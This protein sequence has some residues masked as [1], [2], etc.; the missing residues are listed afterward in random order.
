MTTQRVGSFSALIRQIQEQE[1]RD[2]R[3][4]QP[5]AARP[6]FTPA[7]RALSRLEQAA[8]RIARRAAQGQQPQIR[9]TQAQLR[10]TQAQIQRN[11]QK[12][13]DAAAERARIQAGLSALTQSGVL[14]GTPAPQT[15][16]ATS[17]PPPDRTQL[18]PEERQNLI[19]T[20]G[21][22]FLGE[23]LELKEA[24]LLEER[25]Q[26]VREGILG[27][28]APP[29][30]PISRTEQFLRGVGVSGQDFSRRAGF[31]KGI[32]EQLS[33]LI[34]KT[35]EDIEKDRK[36]GLLDIKRLPP[37]G[38]PTS[39]A[40]AAG[41]GVGGI[42]VPEP[43]TFEDIRRT[44][45]AGGV[46]G[47]LQN[48]MAFGPVVPELE[49]A[50]RAR[51]LGAGNRQ[52]IQ[53]ILR[54][55]FKGPPIAEIAQSLRGPVGVRRAGGFSAVADAPRT[56][57][58]PQ[59]FTA[60][61]NQTEALL[62]SIRSFRNVD[63]PRTALAKAELD[64]L[65]AAGVDVVE[66][67]RLLDD[68]LK[69]RRQEFPSTSEGLA[70][71][72]TERR[73]TWNQIIDALETTV[74]RRSL[75]AGN[76]AI[77]GLSPLRPRVAA[78]S[79]RETPA[80]QQ[81]RTQPRVPEP[82][83]VSRSDAGLPG[84]ME[85]LRQRGPL[86]VGGAQTVSPVRQILIDAR[87]ASEVAEPVGAVRRPRTMG[88]G[89][90][91]PLT[92]EEIG[93]RF[94]APIRPLREVADEVVTSKNPIIR[95]IAGHTGINPS[96]LMDTPTG[97]LLVG[98]ERERVSIDALVDVALQAS[99]DSHAQRFTGR[100]GG[101]IPI[102]K[103]GF[104]GKTN[105][106]WQDVFSRPGAY[107]LLTDQKA[108]IDDFN[109]MIEE[110]ENLRLAYGLDP[111]PKLSLAEGQFY[112]PRS[113]KGIRGIE[114]KR[115][116]NPK[117]HR[118]Y[119][120]ATDGF[121]K[122]IRYD[123]DPRAT[124]ELHLRTAYKEI[125]EKQLADAIEPLS[126]TP[127]ELVKPAIRQRMSAAVKMRI[128]A[129]REV[130]RLRVPRVEK[131]GRVTPEEK[132]LR[133]RLDEQR[134]R[135]KSELDA[136]MAEYKAAK[137]Q[138]RAAMERAKKAEIGPGALFGRVE[139][140]IPIAMWRN[141]FLP[142]EL[143]EQLV[144]G[145]EQIQK[146]AKMATWFRGTEVLG[147][148]I[149]F[150]ASVGD[151]AAQTIQ[152]LPV[153]ARN[154]AAWAGGTLR[155]YQA[156]PDPTVQA[157]FIRDHL[158]T[159]QKMAKNGVTIGDP[160]FFAA[161]RPG[162]GISAGQ[163][164]ERI[165]KGREVRGL[166]RQ[167]GRQSFGR[168]QSSYNSFLTT[169]RALLW[170]AL[171]NSP[172]WA[173]KESELA[174]YINN[175][176]GGL[177]PRAL[178]VGPNRRAVEGVFLA[179]SPRLLRSTVALMA[180][181]VKV[182]VPGGKT[183]RASESLRALGSLVAGA[184]GL[185]VASGLALGKSWEEIGTGLNPLSGKKFLSH[186][187]NGDW[188]GIGGQVRAILQGMTR[189]ASALAPG[190]IPAGV[191]GSSDWLENPILSLYVSRGAPGLAIAGGV[192]EA[193][194]GGK[195]DAQA[196]EKI[197]SLPDLF[198]HIGTSALPFTLQ[199]H[200][201]GEQAITSAFSL[202][203]LRTSPETAFERAKRYVEEAESARLGGPVKWEDVP[204]NVKSRYR[205]VD[206]QGKVLFEAAAEE[207]R[208]R[209][210]ENE[211]VTKMREARESRLIKL[212]SDAE[213]FTKNI[214]SGKRLVQEFQDS[215]KFIKGQYSQIRS[216]HPDIFEKMATR[217][218]SE[219]PEDAAIA[220]FEEIIFDPSLETDDGRDWAEQDRQL[221]ALRDE[222]GE[223]IWQAIEEYQAAQIADYPGPHRQYIS[224]LNSYLRAYDQVADTL[225]TRLSQEVQAQYETYKY[226]KRNR[227]PHE[228]TIWKNAHP[229]LA[230]FLSTVPK[231]KQLL[232]ESNP[233]L[234]RALMTWR[235]NAP[236]ETER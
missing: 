31:L 159:L 86:G 162:G 198:K 172:Q 158:G 75:E 49:I 52:A 222:V 171:E 89:A 37:L 177:N 234:N 122:G 127:K 91:E 3:T 161:L 114:L 236:L 32:G 164:L 147:N 92:A 17:A 191:L 15:P 38:E 178:F 35:Q 143:Q 79:V 24:G 202:V 42:L 23:M 53:N 118:L 61:P 66:P 184:T 221:A 90:P 146:P 175:L 207:Q 215:G 82:E 226:I 205:K 223:D 96:V 123:I 74:A 97:R 128:A 102:N 227:T 13:I 229:A 58:V 156:F 135:A 182:A 2:R 193:G 36:P 151:F 19:G 44:A 137:L 60:K 64:K 201:E 72:R 83:F 150:L 101:V 145:L 176:T 136:V 65:A 231:V 117:L 39:Q 138:Y 199:G 93:N 94:V 21:F 210:F 22:R 46:G 104:F 186:E 87:K 11:R 54:Q 130:R 187:I 216:D 120:E 165:P 180:D 84:M 192:I 153:L 155:H 1:E 169:S 81:A 214:W 225:A 220:R 7:D 4:A 183:V 181:A 185:Y 76:E 208:E 197:D 28:G 211:A 190:G 41:R 100:L 56:M 14:G 119:E 6:L 107:D 129:E 160:E 62:E 174:A 168:F 34:R 95:A 219:L 33:T 10:T 18:T 204:E 166:L 73:T 20:P 55:N 47:A 78:P 29:P 139:D 121:A 212:Q 196:F 142:R 195:V 98:Y 48:L 85:T 88:G 228:A 12:A 232:R 43:T 170:E 213:K 5:V 163:L 116:S 233:E 152:G 70:T 189:V 148:Y 200:L 206:E 9:T 157:R 67:R 167:A 111:R 173:G 141:R 105:K 27:E 203:G 71:F 131:K 109:L 126:I 113:T 124:A 103:E 8:E 51:T 218:K 179:F 134:A 50:S 235:G 30:Q 209:G 115:P 80:P 16:G 224:D 112:V 230:D 108:Y 77:F 26:E 45:E 125:L 144:K 154:P 59:P 110:A 25:E 133:A 99:L 63:E 149:R 217:P 132:A 40:Q 68:L 140:E 57:R 188:I 194:T 69:I 106:L